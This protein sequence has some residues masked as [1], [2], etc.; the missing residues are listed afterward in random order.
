LEREIFERTV[1]KSQFDVLIAPEYE[2]K[3]MLQ[4][5]EKAVWEIWASEHTKV[6]GF[7]HERLA[8]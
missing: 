7:V 2:R 1:C 4:Q 8:V 6:A 5:W 3:D